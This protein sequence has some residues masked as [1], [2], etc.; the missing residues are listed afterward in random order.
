MTLVTIAVDALGVGW[1][2]W[3]VFLLIRGESSGL[4]NRCAALSFSCGLVTNLFA[5]ATILAVAS[6]F[7]LWRLLRLQLRY[8]RKARKEARE[9][10]PTA[11]AIIDRVVGRD[12]LCKV[13]PAAGMI[14]LTRNEIAHLAA[15][16]TT[17][18]ARARHQLGWSVWPGP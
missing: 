11:G 6:S 17:Q 9:L 2:L 5:S 12:E 14:P 7:V 4:D 15:V 1:L 3:F 10:V 16:M 8:W 18:P 13:P